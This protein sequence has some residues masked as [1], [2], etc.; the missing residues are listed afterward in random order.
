[1]G[2]EALYLVIE[3]RRAESV[4]IGYYV[5]VRSVTVSGDG[6]GAFGARPCRAVVRILCAF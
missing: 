6:D 5:G 1:M 2:K 4:S 3:P